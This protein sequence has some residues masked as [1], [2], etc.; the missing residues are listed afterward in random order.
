MPLP[1]S[2]EIKMGG[3][4][5]NSIAQE[6]AGTTSGTPSA[7]QNV[8]L[9]GLSV[10]G[11]NDFQFTGGAATDIAGTPDGNAPFAMSEFHGYS[12]FAWGTPSSLS[13][14]NQSSIFL[15]AQE[16][17]SRGDTCVVCSFNMTLNTTTKIISINIVGTDDGGGF[18][19]DFTGPTMSIAYTGNLNSL[20]ARFVYSGEAISATSAT[21]NTPGKVLELFSSTSSISKFDINNNNITGTS[22]VTSNNN[23]SSGA[24][25]TFRSLRTTSGNMAVALAATSDNVSSNGQSTGKIVFT[26]SDSLKIQLRANGAVIVDLFTKTGSFEMSS[27]TSDA[28]TS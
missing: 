6:K 21:G 1:N 26:G 23:I 19:V 18:D 27:E 17:R 7:V 25:G 12:Q 20:E 4:G 11:V 9:R 28:G 2:G 16:D 22:N 8:S 13:G 24:S 14:S 10:D 5:T 15:M 3:A